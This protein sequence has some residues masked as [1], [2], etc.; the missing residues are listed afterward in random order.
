MAHDVSP[1]DAGPWRSSR[2]A[3]PGS[4]SSGPWGHNPYAPPSERAEWAASPRVS[5]PGELR[6]A[7]PGQ[8][9]LA[10]SIDCALL[11]LV[12]APGIVV[13]QTWD[14]ELGVALWS[15]AL[16]AIAVF[17]WAITATSGQTLGKRWTGLRVITEKGDR[18]GFFRG[19][20]LR[21]WVMWIGSSLFGLPLLLDPFLVFGR[22]RKTLHDHLAGTLVIVADTPGDPY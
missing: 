1:P 15:L 11:G 7:S 19:V 21:V 2:S 17:Q 4:S 22:Q 3:A 12:L 5:S 13:Q 14:T 9:L 8:R 10:K 18:V 16:L 20:F 6:L